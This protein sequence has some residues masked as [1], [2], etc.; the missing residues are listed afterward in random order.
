MSNHILE[1]GGSEVVT[2]AGG[3]RRYR[4]P[5][6]SFRWRDI[7]AILSE[8]VE[9]W[10]KN[11][12]PRLGAALSFYTLLSIA[13]LLLI[14]VSVVS[15]VLGHDSAEADVVSQMNALTGRVGAQAA[16]SLLEASRNTSHGIIAT[17]FGLLTLLFGASG[18]LV[19]LRDALN[20]IWDVPPPKL[21]GLKM[22][23]GFIKERLF[24]FGLVLAV[25]FLLVVS[26]A[27]SAW[28]AAIGAYSARFL[29]A[30]QVI[31]E[32]LNFV[33][34]F[35]INT[36]L[37]SAI[38]KVLPQVRLEWRDVL[39]G[40]AV[41][42]VLF[43]TGKFALGIYLGRATFA[44]TYGAAGSVVVLIIWVYYSAQ[45]FF[46]GAEFTKVFADHFG[47]HPNDRA[48]GA[49]VTPAAAP[50]PTEELP[51]PSVTDSHGPPSRLT[52]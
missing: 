33:L 23:T 46:L 4:K 8:S 27:V 15:M 43:S 20:T 11:N 31:L 50:K 18:V 12:A 51:L 10:S 44:S 42:S 49:M 41:T 38:Y 47:S 48:I 22:V 1:P 16:Q 26:L 13:P 9:G 32:A 5:L 6:I 30:N 35:A 39:L 25:G 36:G 17:V 45:I 24:S 40:G 29:P 3:A 2:A 52:M 7:Q 19:E 37:F 28:I 21:T 34:S 14:L